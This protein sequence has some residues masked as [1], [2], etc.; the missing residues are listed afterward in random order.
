MN[1]IFII[2]FVFYVGLLFRI[3]DLVTLQHGTP[4]TEE[5]KYQRNFLAK[6][7]RQASRLDAKKVVS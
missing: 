5:K 6:M 7:S 4:T 2:I 1:G 3:R